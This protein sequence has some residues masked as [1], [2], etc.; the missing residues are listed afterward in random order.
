MSALPFSLLP[1][2][3][4]VGDNGQLVIGGCDTLELANRFGTPLFVYDEAHLR[5]RCR[6]AVAAFGPGVNYAT[7][8]FL[9]RAMARLAVEEGCNLDVS[10]AGELHVALA[11]GVPAQRLVLHGNNKSVEELRRA[12]TEGVGRVVVDSFDE[13]D[14]IEALVR[15]G[16]PVPQAL[17][18]ITPGVEAHTHEFVRTGQDDSKFG[19]G[20]ASGMAEEAV[21]R[22]LASPAVD[23]VGL[24]AHI[25]SQVFEAR[26]FELAVEALAPFVQRHR[27]P[28]LSLGGGLGVAYVEARRPRPS[29]SGARRCA[30][31]APPRGS[32]PTSPP[33]R[34]GPSSPRPAS[35]STP[36]ARSRTCRASAPTCRSTVA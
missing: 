10:T 24:H 27:L 32:P 21:Q 12:L 11:A 33:S 35:R 19:F 14:R 4:E 7:K 25:G 1:D 8:A 22:A 5:A 29:R 9:C 17:L 13:L 31:P 3:A 15:E 6:E 34:G 36:S 18:R 2:T 20:L 16:L 28:E 23:L 30:T 26:F